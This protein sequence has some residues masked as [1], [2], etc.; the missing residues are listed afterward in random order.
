MP[1]LRPNDLAYVSPLAAARVVEP[2]PAAMWAVY[3]VLAALVAAT[4]WAALAKVDIVAKAPARIVADGRDQVI[5][6]LEGGIL[7][8]LHVR[9][10]DAVVPGQPLAT[11]DATRFEAVQAEGQA[12]RL[13]LRAAIARL[14]AEA[15][16]R[17]PAFPPEVAAERRVADGEMASYRARQQALQ[18]GLSAQ[19]R[20]IELVRRELAVASRMA[21]QG[22]MSEVEVMRLERQLNELELTAQDRVNRFRQEAQ[23]E[24][25]RQRNELSA[26]EEQ[27]VARDDAVRRTVLRSPVRGIVKQVRANTPG[28]VIAPGAAVMEIVPR[29]ERVLVEARIRPADIGFVQVGQPVT[30][31]LTAYDPVVYG[32]LEGTL[33]RISPDAITDAER[34]PAGEAYYRALV[35]SASPMLRAGVR[36]LPLRPGMTGTAEV[37]TGQRTVLDFV[38]RPL[39]RSQEAL[40]ER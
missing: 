17:A 7:R 30:M 34:G 14:E 18:D 1:A 31:K 23:G 3:L 35:E 16:G 5:A 37:R 24:L 9:D 32:G 38:L 40:R 26:L 6:S 8:E 4:A 33:V 21:A 20:G 12:R 22:L 2:A 39:L 15:A 10:G 28:G 11:L 29:G 36:E 25:V 27:M 13:A 19:R